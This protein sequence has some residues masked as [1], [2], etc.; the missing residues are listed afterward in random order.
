MICGEIEI[1][2]QYLWLS[3]AQGN[4]PADSSDH[5]AWL[6]YNPELHQIVISFRTLGSLRTRW[7]RK[8]DKTGFP[9]A[10]LIILLS[11]R[12]AS[13][14]QDYFFGLL[15]LASDAHLDAF[16]P[17]YKSPANTVTTRFGRCL[18]NQQLGPELLSRAG[19]SGL[20]LDIPS[21]AAGFV[22]PLSPL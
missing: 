8:S 3:T 15:G 7:E 19:L 5:E 16:K 10:D 1:P 17:D 14:T 22:G 2:W 6:N 13:V 20:R 21:W 4:V 9:L 12:L 18:I 11:G